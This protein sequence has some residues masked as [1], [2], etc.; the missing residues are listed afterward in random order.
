M[1]LEATYTKEANGSI[2][3]TIRVTDSGDFPTINVFKSPSE[4]PSDETWSIGEG[5]ESAI[6]NTLP[7]PD[8]TK[9]WVTSQINA[10][11]WNLDHWRAIWVPESEE[12]EI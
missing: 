1:K 10:L 6:S 4:N 11:K 5:T 2:K 3:A 8:E 7:G 12:F 9:Q